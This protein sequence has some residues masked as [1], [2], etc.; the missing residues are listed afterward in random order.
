MDWFDCYKKRITGFSSVRL[1]LRAPR[2]A[3]FTQLDVL[4]HAKIMS[5]VFMQILEFSSQILCAKPPLVLVTIV[6]CLHATRK[7]LGCLFSQT[8]KG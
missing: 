6:V 3:A 8:E 4:F 2:P 5:K 1:C 7:Y